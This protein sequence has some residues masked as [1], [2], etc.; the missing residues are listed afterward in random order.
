[1]Q[2][3]NDAN[4]LLNDRQEIIAFGTGSSACSEHEW[5]S[6][7]MQADLCKADLQT[8]EQLIQVLRAGKAVS[9]P[10][11]LD[12]KAIARNLD[13]LTFKTGADENGESIAVLGYSPHEGAVSLSHSQLHLYR[14]SQNVAGAWD[15]GSFAVK[16]R[17]AEMVARLQQFYEGMLAGEGLFAGTFL[18]SFERDLTGVIIARRDR[19]QPE[20]QAAIAQAQ[21][22][23]EA[24]LRLKA[25]SELDKFDAVIRQRQA[26]KL[27][28]RHPG[29]LWPVWRDRKVDGEV[30]Y[31]LNPGYGFQSYSR[32][33]FTIDEL[34]SWANAG[35]VEPL[36]PIK[37]AA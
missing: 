6:K 5:G 7:S 16:V 11:L 23:W 18:A 17:G 36:V 21:A 22:D 28:A 25:R 4:V 14:T 10:Q 3:G 13:R 35:G 20:H 29:Y 2:R 30:V 24:G 27:P 33:Y 8:D 32:G 19:L 9:Y 15:E 26:Q 1:M 37:D 12:R 31:Q 34:L